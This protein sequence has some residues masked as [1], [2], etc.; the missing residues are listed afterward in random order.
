[1]KRLS[2]AGLPAMGVEVKIVGDK[3]QEVQPGEKGEI[4]VRSNKLMKEYWKMPEQTA[5]V[6][7]NGWFHTG[8]MGTMDEGG[9]IYIVDRKSD[10][11]ISGGF[12]IYPREVEEVI[13]THPGVAEAAVIGVPDDIWGESVKAFVVIRK[14]IEVSPEEIIEHC[15]QNLAGYKKPKT[16]DFIEEIPKNLY[17]KIDRRALKEPFWKNSDRRVH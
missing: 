15:Q 13:M 16:V 17:G 14:G 1:M 6:F 9:Y 5:E 4:I 2:S 11:I 7:K 12:N 3:D 10:M 8:D